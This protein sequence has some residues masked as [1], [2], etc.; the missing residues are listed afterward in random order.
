MSTRCTNLD[1][2]S[3]IG[4]GSEILQFTLFCDYSALAEQA[5]SSDLRT[6]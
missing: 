4:H 3:I 1:A 6:A 2:V 5:D